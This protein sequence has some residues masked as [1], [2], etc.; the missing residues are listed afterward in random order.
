MSVLFL[1]IHSIFI[2]VSIFSTVCRT[3]VM[4]ISAATRAWC[5]R[6]AK[7]VV[8]SEFVM[9]T[10]VFLMF[11]V[12]LT[13]VCVSLFFWFLG[14]MSVGAFSMVVCGVAA[15]LIVMG[16]DPCSYLVA[17]SLADDST[18][19]QDNL[20]SVRHH[21]HHHHHH[22]H[23]RHSRNRKRGEQRRHRNPSSSKGKEGVS[24]SAS[25]ADGEAAVAVVMKEEGVILAEDPPEARE[26]DSSDDI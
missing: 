6:W 14:W 2:F 25:S 13:V 21:H 10:A 19:E 24:L 26:K 12:G 20:A 15:C 18:M 23:N 9:A 16:L 11:C 4:M 1:T 8:V 17:K 5:R 3:S 22:R 7:R